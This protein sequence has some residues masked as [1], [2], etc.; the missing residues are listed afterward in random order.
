MRSRFK[1]AAFVNVCRL[2]PLCLLS[3]LQHPDAAAQAAVA[4]NCGTPVTIDD[5]IVRL[6][7]LK[8]PPLEDYNQH[9]IAEIIARGHRAGSS[10]VI[11]AAVRIDVDR[12]GHITAAVPVDGDVDYGKVTANRLRHEVLIPFQQNGQP[13]CI[14]GVLHSGLLIR[15]E[16]GP[17]FKNKDQ[18]HKM[19]LKCLDLSRSAPSNA[20]TLSS[21]RQA[22]DLG[23][24]LPP[25]YYGRDIRVANVTT[26]TLL[27]LADQRT[28][29]LLYAEQAVHTVDQ[30]YDNATGKAAAYGVRGQARAMTG[31]IKG[32][33]DDLTFAESL[34]RAALDLSRT[35]EEKA[36]DSHALKSLF[37]FH[38]LVLNA[39]HDEPDAKRLQ[40]EAQQL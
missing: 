20:D 7:L 37:G 3:L 13:V 24:T 30:G 33:L 14:S 16:I 29:A 27:L 5:T 17:E 22:A 32:A 1:I 38:A 19:L 6:H 25:S 8:S 11:V 40:Q 2:L 31:V 12:Q 36:L 10:T 35:P 34:D 21:C 23:N 39:L 28:E 15:P 18:F 9:E 4:G 26:A